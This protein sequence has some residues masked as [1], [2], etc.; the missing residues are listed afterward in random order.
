M[1]LAIRKRYV[2]PD[3]SKEP[4]QSFTILLPTA[5]TYRHRAEEAKRL[6]MQVTHQFLVNLDVIESAEVILQILQAT[7][8]GR[9][10]LFR[11]MSGE[12]GTT[13]SV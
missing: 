7:L 6:A 3:N 5:E 2:A 9:Q 10:A 12:Q 4:A 13:I 1:R 11:L 8:K